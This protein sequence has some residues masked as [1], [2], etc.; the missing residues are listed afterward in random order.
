MKVLLAYDG[1]D[2]SA[3]AVAELPLLGLPAAVDLTVLSV[4]DIWMPTPG[5]DAADV[6]LSLSP[7]LAALRLKTGEHLDAAHNLA[8][9]GAVKVRQLFPGWQVAARAVADS[10]GW[11]IVRIAGELAAD[12]VIVGSHGRGALGRVLLG[13]VSQRVLNSG[14]GSVHV[15]RPRPSHPGF[16]FRVLVAVDG[17]ADSVAAVRQLASRAWPAG[18]VIRLLAVLDPRLESV[19]A[20]PGIFPSEWA[21]S[22]ETTPREWICHLVEHFAQMLYAAHLTAETAIGEGDP[23][24]EILRQAED[25]RAD[26]LVLGAH[27]LHHGAQRN[28]GSVAGAVAARAHCSVEIIRPAVG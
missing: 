5:A 19:I 8:N 11:A 12:W 25:F 22:H 2:C 9:E 14:P 4:A 26:L 28:L 10:P 18:T 3:H 27:G 1:S 24:Q 17:S 20:W 23:K 16:P 21:R 13:S 6:D 15:S 7:G